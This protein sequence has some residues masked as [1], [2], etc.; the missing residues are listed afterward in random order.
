MEANLD[1]SGAPNVVTEP[2]S[3]LPAQYFGVRRKQA[4][5]QQLMIAV[6]H[7]ALDCIEKHRFATHTSGRRLY[8]EAQQWFMAREAGWPFSFESI[9]S[10]LDLDA[11]A[12][13][14]RLGVLS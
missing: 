1:R 7:D 5:E 8:R 3:V 2:Y 11:N 13:R 6:L 10:A 12:V 14:Q 9:C 4:P